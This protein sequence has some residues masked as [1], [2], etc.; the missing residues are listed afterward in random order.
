MAS[1]REIYENFKGEERA[2]AK[3]KKLN[4]GFK[5]GYRATE[6]MYSESAPTA[7]SANT[8]KVAER[9]LRKKARQGADSL[10]NKS[11]NKMKELGID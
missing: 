10:A 7:T 6:S 4:P 9:S 8:A 11:I 1:E 2:A 5:P 3:Y